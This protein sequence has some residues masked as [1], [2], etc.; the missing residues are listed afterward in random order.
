MTDDSDTAEQYKY[1]NRVDALGDLPGAN[2]EADVL[3]VIVHRIASVDPTN[4]TERELGRVR[5][6]DT[7]SNEL[8]PAKEASLQDLLAALSSDG[9]DSLLIES[10]SPLD[11]SAAT[12]PVS[13]QGVIDVSSRDGRNL[14]DVDVTALPEPVSVSAA[15]T[16]PVEQQTPVDTTADARHG[17]ASVTVPAGEIWTVEGGETWVVDDITVN[18]TLDVRGTGELASY[19]TIGGTGTITGDGAVTKRS[20]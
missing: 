5:L 4:D 11:A 3:D 10:N 9:T 15:S 18:G 17:A 12:V 19:G 13:H 7:D 20:T 14:G 8:I 6:M 1:I 16:L 2:R